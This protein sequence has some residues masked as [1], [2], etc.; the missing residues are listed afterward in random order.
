[1]VY[2]ETALWL[3]EQDS[4][5]QRSS[6][7]EGGAAQPSFHGVFCRTHLEKRP[8]ERVLLE[9]VLRLQPG[10]LHDFVCQRL[11]Q[12][13]LAPTEIKETVIVSERIQLLRAKKDINHKL[14]RAV[15]KSGIEMSIFVFQKEQGAQKKAEHNRGFRDQGME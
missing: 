1:M 6:V 14:M 9:R 7:N 15:G 13:F 2:V 11:S 5:V 12:D 10:Q 4:R 3:E 8:S